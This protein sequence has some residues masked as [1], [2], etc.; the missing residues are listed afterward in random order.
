MTEKNTLETAIANIRKRDARFKPQ[1]F[2]FTMQALEQTYKLIKERRH[3]SGQELLE[4]IRQVALKEF[5]FLARHTLEQWGL[6]ATGDFGD[7]VFLLIEEGMLSKTESDR[8]EDFDDV[9]DF[10]NAFDK[11]FE[12]PDEIHL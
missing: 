8:R 4:G 2:Y 1:A 12:F 3:V 7:I 6:G 9:Y 11:S 5:G 10:E